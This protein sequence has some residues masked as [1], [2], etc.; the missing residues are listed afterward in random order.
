[1][2]CWAGEIT[3]V[4]ILITATL[5]HLATVPLMLGVALL[6]G[7]S[8]A[9]FQPA[10]TALGPMLVPRALLPRAIAWNS[11]AGQSASIV[12]PAL[13]GVLVAIS[14]T[15]A[16][17]A[18]LALY[19][20]AATALAFIARSAAPTVQPGSRWVLVKEGLNY[21]WAN[22]IVFGAISLDLAAVILGGATAL[23]PAFARDVLHVGPQGCG[24][25]RAGPAMGGAAGAIFLATR[26]IR[27]SVVS[28]GQDR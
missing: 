9:F 14:P 2:I 1:M 7:V 11:L 23:L 3:A 8:R 24:I 18:S 17:G 6:F 10:N 4:T 21:V 25:L 12:G 5:L 27:P 28:T 20:A 22:K 13:A 19:V 26:P 16:Y 15:A